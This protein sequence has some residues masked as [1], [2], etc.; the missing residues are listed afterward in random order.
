MFLE[1]FFN[2]FDSL[3]RRSLLEDYEL[4][5]RCVRSHHVYQCHRKLQIQIVMLNCFGGMRAKSSTR[6]GIAVAFGNLARTYYLFEFEM[7]VSQFSIGTALEEVHLEFLSRLFLTGEL[8]LVSIHHQYLMCLH[9]CL[10]LC[11][12][13]FRTVCFLK[14]VGLESHLPRHL[15][16]AS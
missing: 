16:P 6:S 7:Q 5:T 1:L 11:R 12:R 4:K 14:L 9:Q 10:I 3:H 15:V 2:D 13:R 8:V